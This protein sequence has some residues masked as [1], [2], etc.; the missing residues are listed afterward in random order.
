VL[1][2]AAVA[3]AVAVAVAQLVVVEVRVVERLEASAL[4]LVVADQ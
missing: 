3:V 4:E 1:G 2:V